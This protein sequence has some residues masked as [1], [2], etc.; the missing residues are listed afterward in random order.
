LNN[1]GDVSV[2][3]VTYIEVLSCPMNDEKS[4][5]VRSFLDSLEIINADRSIVEECIRIRK[6]RKLKIPDCIIAA[7]ALSKNLE[8]VTRSENDFMAVVSR[9]IN[10]IDNTL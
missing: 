6:A 1:L 2:S 8:L 7:T 9:I 3:F 5:K 10:P 4:E